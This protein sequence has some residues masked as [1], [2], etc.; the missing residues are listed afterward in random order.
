MS[1]SRSWTITQVDF[2]PG[3]EEIMG[4]FNKKVDC[5]VPRRY[6]KQGLFFFPIGLIGLHDK[7]S[8]L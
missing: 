8:R 5:R 1:S 2:G 6:L 7:R 4:G 3:L